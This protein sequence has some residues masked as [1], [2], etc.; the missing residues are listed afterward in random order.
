MI[1]NDFAS[2]WAMGGHAAYVWGAVV[3][4]LLTMTLE[5]A[6]LTLRDRDLASRAPAHDLEE[7]EPR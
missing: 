6:A 5:L 3:G 2:F 7:K 1:W 4:V